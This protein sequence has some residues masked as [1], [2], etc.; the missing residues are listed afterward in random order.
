MIANTLAMLV[1]RM[2]PVI[3]FAAQCPYTRS[4]KSDTTDVVSRSEEHTS[5]LQ[6][7]RHLV[8]RLL[9]EKKNEDRQ[10]F[11]RLVARGCH[12]SL[13]GRLGRGRGQRERPCLACHPPRQHHSD[14]QSL[15]FFLQRAPPRR[16]PLL[17]QQ[18]RFRG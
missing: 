6:S 16:L 4:M 7:L 15:V 11:G 5:E 10:D 2:R 9:L 17:P 1:H 12:A 8:C 18:P 13:A 3:R 14:L